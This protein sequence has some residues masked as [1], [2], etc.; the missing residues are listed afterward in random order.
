MKVFNIRDC[1]YEEYKE[2]IIGS[3]E[4]E[5]HSVYLVYGEVA[6]GESRTMAPDG[7]DEILLLLSGE[8]TI[9]SNGMKI[10]LKKEQALYMKPDE[11]CTLNVLTDCRYVIAGTHTT[12]HDH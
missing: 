5:K 9:E 7:H 2:F 6:K 11:T 4:I 10:S 8:V 1:Y 3:R 12:P